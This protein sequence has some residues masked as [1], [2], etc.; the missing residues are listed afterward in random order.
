MNIKKLTIFYETASCLNMSKV[1][2]KMYI[3]Q[4][5]ISQMIS[6]LE[7]DIG[8]KVFDRIGNKLYLTHE[9]EVLLNYTRR[10]LNL[11]NEGIEAVKDYSKTGK[12]S[13]GA[14]TTIGAYMMPEILKE[15]RKVYPYV[16]LSLVVDNKYHI[17]ELLLNNKVDIA[18]IE[19]ISSSSEFISEEIWKDELVFISS[20]NHL[21]AQKDDLEIDDLNNETFIVRE[22]GSGTHEVFE[23]FMKKHKL[24][25]SKPIISNSIEAIINY[26]KLDMG[27]GCL[28]YV[29]VVKHQI[30]QEVKV[31]R[32]NGY[33][34]ERS[35]FMDIH[36]DKHIFPIMKYFMKFCK[37]FDM[38]KN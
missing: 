27:V 16:N 11:Y 30:L 4:P 26:V 8:S 1:A 24:K 6:E 5:A 23:A 9:G 35:L 37:E 33:K 38:Y 3:S 7:A 15:F 12:L 31:L 25:Y 14:T 21:W 18:F 32:I 22:E 20:T 28:S 17:E 29:S 19:N 13:I 36:K 10:I 2:K 34:M